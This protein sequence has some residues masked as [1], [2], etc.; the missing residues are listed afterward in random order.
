MKSKKQKKAYYEPLHLASELIKT[1]VLKS[2]NLMFKQFM[3]AYYKPMNLA[4]ELLEM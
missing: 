4:F 1:L 3:K 2:V